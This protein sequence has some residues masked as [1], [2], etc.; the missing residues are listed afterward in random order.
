MPSDP[1]DRIARAMYSPRGLAEFRA[2]QARTQP[3]VDEGHI[4]EGHITETEAHF[5]GSLPMQLSMIRAGAS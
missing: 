5:L 1:R 4:D 3:L 2:Y